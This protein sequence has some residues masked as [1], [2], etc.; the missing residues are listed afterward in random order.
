MDYTKK[1]FNLTEADL[2]WVEQTFASMTQEEKLNQV[3][4]DMLWNN[5]PIVIHQSD[6]LDG[7]TFY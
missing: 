2:T 5:P 1:P 4:V 6:L 7:L 3:F